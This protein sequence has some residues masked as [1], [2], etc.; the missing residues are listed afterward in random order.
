MRRTDKALSNF[1]ERDNKNLD[2]LRYSYKLTDNQ[3]G[4]DVF[5][6]REMT[7]DEKRMSAVIPFADG[8]SRDGVGDLLEIGGIDFSRHRKNPISL[9]DHGKNV[10][11]PIGL[12]EDP[13]THAYT[14]TVD[15]VN[16]FADMNTFFYQGKGIQGID[17][18]EEYDHAVFCEQLYHMLTKRLI[19][20]GSIGYQVV[21]ARELN[22]DYETGT[23]KGLHLLKTLMLEGSLVVLP[24]NKDTVRKTLSMPKI[25]GKEISPI[26]VKSLTPYAGQ[27]K[28]T[29]FVEKKS[30][31]LPTFDDN[32][33]KKITSNNVE[34]EVYKETHPLLES[35]KPA[36]SLFK[37]SKSLRKKYRKMKDLVR[38][39]KKSS[40]GSSIVYIENSAY[41]EVK[42]LAIDKGL[43]FKRI[44]SVDHDLE[45][46]RLSGDDN[47]ID[48][49]AKTYGCSLKGVKSMAKEMK[50]EVKSAPDS[51]AGKEP[52][53]STEPYGAQVLRRMHEDHK[54]LL[55][56]YDELAG[57]MEH[58]AVKKHLTKTLEGI[59]SHLDETEGLFKKHY[60]DLPPLAD[61]L[62]DPDNATEEDATE[63]TDV[64]G[65]TKEIDDPDAIPTD[66]G[67]EELES[68]D[69][70]VESMDNNPGMGQKRLKYSKNKNLPAKTK[71]NA[72]AGKNADEENKETKS[73]DEEMKEEKKIKAMD[74]GLDDNE[75]KSL[76]RVSKFLKA[77]ADSPDY[78]NDMKKLSFF[79]GKSM[80]DMTG[81]DDEKMYHKSED[82]SEFAGDRD[83][84]AEEEAEAEHKK[85][86]HPHRKFIQNLSKFLKAMSDENVMTQ[87]HRA[88]A[89]AYAEDIDKIA[90]SKTVDEDKVEKKSVEDDEKKG[91][92]SLSQI[93]NANA[94][95][96]SDAME[97]LNGITSKLSSVR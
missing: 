91:E 55:S 3:Y 92:K 5:S 85:N 38:R 72:C 83:W 27:K 73:V 14:I 57:P 49:I 94:K 33:I 54:H 90:E 79:H 65:D 95:M 36:V 78:G 58:E 67:E 1:A 21:A 22:P 61:S 39:V 86:L 69:E 30:E 9:F 51:M 60:K 41:D 20:A 77:M 76:K 18:Q 68:S 32:R 62:D 48:N 53:H 31:K 17:K 23:P 8:N 40:P 37:S 35:N 16:Q 97:K 64:E 7:F 66:S 42:Q 46:I 81:D 89:K 28:A 74:N 13:E 56:D 59:S 24:A 52:K 26:L 93:V 87:E 11:L 63:A 10:A 70:A 25:C 6:T 2:T 71:C 80:D 15:V 43:E 45:K 84:L 50:R 44:A 75:K 47:V 82:K 19:R 4:L 88:A 12:T 34:Q 96:I 29:L